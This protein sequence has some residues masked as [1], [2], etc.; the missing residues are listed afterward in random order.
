[1]LG[2]LVNRLLLI[3]SSVSGALAATALLPG[4]ALATPLLDYQAIRIAEALDLKCH[5]LKFVEHSYLPEIAENFLAQTDEGMAYA[6]DLMDTTDFQSWQDGVDAEAR[7]KADEIGCTEAA[8]PYLLAARAAANQQIYQGLVLASHFASDAAPEKFRTPLE[9]E[10]QQAAG[11]YENFLRQVYGESYAD[12]V[13]RQ[14]QAAA[15]RLPRTA[16]V[17]AP[18]PDAGWGDVGLE[19]LL[20]TIMSADDVEAIASAQF[21]GRWAMDHVALE[22]FA[23]TNGWAVWPLATADGGLYPTLIPQDGSAV[24]VPLWQDASRYALSN[25][26]ALTYVIGQLPDGRLRLM[27][28]GG[29]A[30]ALGTGA[31]VRLYIPG[32]LP[33]GVSASAFFER[34]DFRDG[35]QAFD[36][37]PVSGARCL[38]GPCFDFGPEAAAAALAFG[39]GSIIELFITPDSGAEP[40]PIAET[41]LRQGQIAVAGLARVAAA[42]P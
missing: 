8:S 16:F 38:G 2:A 11:G 25:G 27:T 18:N 19:T 7:A 41:P 4:P 29:G 6:N 28:F 10:K 37:K 31:T 1:M 21:D 34:P 9:I 24:Q 23:E 22:V 3:L 20:S 39:A 17:T 35:A 15:Q 5:A 32:A 26:K 33:E 36:A 12:F 14:R 40:R 42:K 30:D 13:E